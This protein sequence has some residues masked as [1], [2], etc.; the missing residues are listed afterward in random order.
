MARINDMTGQDNAYLMGKVEEA[1]VA[2]YGRNLP[3][4]TFT[5]PKEDPK[6]EGRIYFKV[7][8]GSKI[9]GDATYKPRRESVWVA[10]K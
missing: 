3:K 5:S 6:V 4:V 2:R 9:I 10:W 7:K 8:K 1:H